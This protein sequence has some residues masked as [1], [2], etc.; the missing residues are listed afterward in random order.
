MKTPTEI[1]PA[2]WGAAGGALVLG[3]LG[4]TWGGWVTGGSAEAAAK[5]DAGQAVVEVLASICVHQFNSQ[6]DVAAKLGE[7][8]ALA[9]YERGAFVEK[10]GWATMPGSD[11][12]IIGVPQN[13]AIK[14]I[15]A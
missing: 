6:A 15:G 1:K 12:P 8:K 14:L 4:F 2:L 5:K 10:G 11:K 7:L 13:C 3:I 9:S